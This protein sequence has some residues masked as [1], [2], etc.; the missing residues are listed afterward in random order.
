MQVQ[1]AFKD[2]IHQAAKRAS[3]IATDVAQL[4]VD[5]SKA[6]CDEGYR[7]SFIACERE[8]ALRERAIGKVWQIAEM[9]HE[10]AQ[11]IPAF[12]GGN[13]CMA[14]RFAWEML[15][16]IREEIAKL[17]FAR[18]EAIREAFVLVSGEGVR[19]VQTLLPL[20]HGQMRR[21]VNMR[22]RIEQRQQGE[23]VF[24][25]TVHYKN[26]P[27]RKSVRQA[28]IR[29][30]NH[31][32]KRTQDL[33]SLRFRYSFVPAISYQDEINNMARIGTILDP[34]LLPEIRRIGTEG[35]G[36]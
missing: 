19:Q 34:L 15:S 11:S 23:S 18:G 32:F 5:L 14:Q 17:F 8:K 31:W 21:L 13:A 6:L 22:I 12:V 25:T 16:A 20:N 36:K 4:I 35:G 10:K 28:E 2:T 7:I 26:C 9:I 3:V 30:L 24:W 33:Y 1:P 27:L 29:G